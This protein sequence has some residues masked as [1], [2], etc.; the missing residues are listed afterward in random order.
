[1]FLTAQ[2]RNTH[3][4]PPNLGERDHK[5]KE[6][7]KGKRRKMIDLVTNLIMGCVA[8]E[9]YS[10]VFKNVS[11][12]SKLKAHSY[13]LVGMIAVNSLHFYFSDYLSTGVNA[14]MN[15]FLA[16]MLGVV[17]RILSGFVV[18]LKSFPVVK[19]S[20]T[21]GVLLGAMILLI[22]MFSADNTI[23]TETMNVLSAVLSGL[24]LIWIQILQY[25]RR[26][27]PK[28]I[29][30]LIAGGLSIYFESGLNFPALVVLFIATHD[31]FRNPVV[32]TTPNLRTQTQSPAS[33]S[34]AAPFPVAAATTSTPRSPTSVAG[35]PV[36]SPPDGRAVVVAPKPSTATPTVRSV[37][38]CS[39]LS[40]S[41][42]AFSPNSNTYYFIRSYHH[43]YLTA[44]MERGAHRVVQSRKA[45]R[46]K[47]AWRFICANNT[48]DGKPLW[49]LQN[50]CYGTYLRGGH[51]LDPHVDH[52]S[53]CNKW[54]EWKVTP[55]SFRSKEMFYLQISEHL[56]CA[57]H[58][59]YLQAGGEKW[60]W[61]IDCT[62][63]NCKWEKWYLEKY[64]Y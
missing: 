18:A 60:D 32:A 2:L 54:E 49:Y 29:L 22:F 28:T 62:T 46:G 15:N 34:P 36:V 47:S 44:T 9:I 25:G 43:R 45:L 7:D 53:C 21:A 20:G 8:Q 10:N 35:L 64:K 16:V 57:E 37:A 59:S 55:T 63:D 40:I 13:V 30:F 48:M 6:R 4:R 50:K 56:S 39:A 11:E 3:T 52:S 17:M 41:N 42:T 51:H 61:S 1:V 12:E 38:P 23:F 33:V 5:K 19:H 58:G 27:T 31:C 24:S 26:F 14:H